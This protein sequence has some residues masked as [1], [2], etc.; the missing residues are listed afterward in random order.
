MK[1]SGWRLAV[2]AVL[3]VGW[4]SYLAYLAATTTEPMVLSRPQFLVA[5]LYVI[6]DVG[7]TRFWPTYPELAA[8]PAGGPAA[9]A[10]LDAKAPAKDNTPGE[11]VTVREVVWAARDT[12]LKLERIYVKN[13][14]RSGVKKQPKE[15]PSSL[16]WPGHGEYILALSHTHD[17]PGVFRV[18]LEPRT[19]GFP[20][21]LVQSQVE[22]VGA[23][24]YPVTPQTLEQL[25][26][27]K[28][29]YH[30]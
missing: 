8:V 19:P 18:T 15:A 4:I 14:P 6:A 26:R 12:D 22:L 28:A 17:G 13:L 20:G 5:D 27:I 9:A 23:P 25:R 2:S 21:H 1:R 29:E 7:T 24:I 10:L 11:V 30:P 3:F 16:V